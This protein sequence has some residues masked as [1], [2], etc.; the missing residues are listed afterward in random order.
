MGLEDKFNSIKN[1]IKAEVEAGKDA[2][3]PKEIFSRLDEEYKTISDAYSK[4]G[5]VLDL[6]FVAHNYYLLKVYEFASCDPKF[7]LENFRLSLEALGRREQKRTYGERLKKIEKY[8]KIALKR[9]CELVV[10]D[11]LTMIAR[12]E[13]RNEL[14]S[15]HNLIVVQIPAFGELDNKLIEVIA[16]CYFSDV[17]HAQ[18][19]TFAELNQCQS[20]MVAIEEYASRLDENPSGC[21]STTAHSRCFEYLY[22]I[23]KKQLHW[24]LRSRFHEKD[25]EQRKRLQDFVERIVPDMTCYAKKSVQYYQSYIDHFPAKKGSEIPCSIQLTLCHKKIDVLSAEYYFVAYKEK[26][27]F[28]AWK[29]LD[30][31]RHFIVMSKFRDGIPIP[32]G[33][34]AFFVE[35]WTLL[36]IFAKMILLKTELI[37]RKDMLKQDW[38][39]LLFDNLIQMLE[40][41][42]KYFKM[43]ISKEEDYNLRIIAAQFSG[44]FSE[45]FIYDLLLDYQVNSRI[46]DQTSKEFIALLQAVK[47]AKKDDI[48][49]NEFV[50]PGKP[51]IDIFIKPHIAISLKNAHL[52]NRFGELDKEFDLFNELGIQ[53]VWVGINFLKNIRELDQVSAKFEGLKAKYPKIKIEIFDIKDFV[54]V[55]LRELRRHGTSKLNF[56]ELDIY[57]VLDY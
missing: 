28:K 55:L 52:P 12:T 30:E 50:I 20:T 57:K 49:R 38:E 13:I 43:E 5:N 19:K 51:D 46:D 42:K 17:E 39:C 48:K 40:D 27:V 32:E 34:I 21:V 25:D 47:N 54:E 4:G 10:F 44:V 24:A 53:T 9:I 15:A 2:S 35:E 56:P 33:V 29:K 23:R 18:I 37:N 1:E 41:A 14:V 22:R 45:Y 3:L 26:S 6:Q 7:A 16:E 11:D 31:I 36:D 8:Y